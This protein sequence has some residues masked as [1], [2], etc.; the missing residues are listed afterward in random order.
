M[1]GLFMATTAHSPATMKY[2]RGISQRGVR[3][4]TAKQQAL[5]ESRVLSWSFQKRKFSIT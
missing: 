5:R 4:I 3:A 2:L 1:K